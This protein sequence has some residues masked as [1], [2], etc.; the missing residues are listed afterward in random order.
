MIGIN[1]KDIRAVLFYFHRIA[2]VKEQFVILGRKPDE[3]IFPR[4]C[5]KNVVKSRKSSA[6]KNVT[7]CT[8]RERVPLLPGCR[9][10]HFHEKALFTKQA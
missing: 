10:I 1:R 4:I 2:L 7:P 9:P 5:R 6:K 8:A 3:Y